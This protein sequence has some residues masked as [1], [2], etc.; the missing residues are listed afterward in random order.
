MKSC[1]PPVKC[2]HVTDAQRLDL[3][4]AVERARQSGMD[5]DLM[6]VCFSRTVAGRARDDGLLPAGGL[7]VMWVLVL[8]VMVLYAMAILA[9]RLIGHG[10][11]LLH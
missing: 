6:L 1:A 7:G 11:I 10:V 5:I 3:T 9:T 2:P 4:L 8:T